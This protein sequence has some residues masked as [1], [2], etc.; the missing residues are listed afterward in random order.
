MKA[1]RYGPLERAH[2]PGTWQAIP[3]HAWA[4]RQAGLQIKLRSGV[5][6]GLLRM[7]HT[8]GFR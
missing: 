6:V 8:I 4:R 5:G 2:L 1:P 3:G 7:L